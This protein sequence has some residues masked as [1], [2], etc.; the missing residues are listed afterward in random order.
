MRKLLFYGVVFFITYGSLYPFEFS[1]VVSDQA[2]R[3]FLN[4]AIVLSS[5][6][7][8]VGNVVLFVPFGFLGY[9]LLPSWVLVSI[10]LL[11]AVILQIAQLFLPSREP[12]IY[13][14][15][16]NFL[17]I[18]FGLL[19]GYVLKVSPLF[20]NNFCTTNNQVAIVII[21]LWGA[22]QLLP[23]VPTLDWQSF[24]SAL[25]PLTLP[26]FSWE[27]TS[28]LTFGW[29]A[30][31]YFSR[32]VLD[33]NW[34]TSYFILGVVSILLLKIMIVS[35][36]LNLTDV[37][38]GFFAVLIYLFLG[39]L[40]ARRIVYLAWLILFTYTLKSLFPFQWQSE[41]KSFIWLPLSGFLDGSMIINSKALCEKLFV[42]VCIFSLL[43]EAKILSVKTISV[44]II[45]IATIEI[46]QLWIAGRTAEITDPLLATIIAWLIVRLRNFTQT[47]SKLQLAETLQLDSRI[48]QSNTG[49]VNASI[50]RG[51][52]SREA[53]SPD[54]RVIVTA[55]VI[56]VVIASCLYVLLRMPNV[57]YNIRELFKYGGNGIDLFI[58]ALALLAMGGAPAW[59]GYTVAKAKNFIVTAPMTAIKVSAVIYILIFASVTDESI[60]DIAG[61]SVIV[62]R[63]GEKGV[64]GTVGKQFVAAVGADNL[65]NV[66]DIFEPLV[67][68]GALFGPL[69]IFLGLIFAAL[70]K[71]Q[72]L[73]NAGN[74][75]H[76]WLFSKQLFIY[77]LYMLPW[78]YFCKVIAFDWSSTDNLNE[79]IARDGYYRMGGGGYLYVLI[80][81][82]S[83]LAGVLAWA[84]QYSAFFTI[85]LL[86][87]SLFSV[88]PGWLLINAGLT[89]NVGKYGLS[90]SGV[91]FL[92]GPDRTHLLSSR[93]LFFRWSL[94]QYSAILGLASGAALYLK[95]LIRGGAKNTI[96]TKYA[97]SNSSILTELCGE[98]EINQI[99]FVNG[100][101][102][103]MGK[104]FSETVEFIVVFF[105]D[106]MLNSPD[107]NNI[108]SAKIKSELPTKSKKL[109]PVVLNLSPKQMK[110]ITKIQ[111]DTGYSC[112]EVIGNMISVFM[113]ISK[114]E[115][116][117]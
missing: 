80:A 59:M 6:G 117:N 30:V 72:S 79:L 46:C 95:L 24:K 58:F 82:I 14:V 42:F 88:W 57:P 101:A 100:F 7:D 75:L 76:S 104:S 41:G 56:S 3:A 84:I 106:E 66:T 48:L 85:L 5:I 53:F 49:F 28:F 99:E 52:N 19:C 51:Q 44:V 65:R 50:G 77:L 54:W 17:G 92:L 2:F 27:R 29:L 111:V 89:N 43:K 96:Q 71:T 13:D 12:A 10:G 9:R 102:Q 20:K 107:S 36:E 93:E 90:F 116:Q 109:L 38:A 61:S 87:I 4:S 73:P 55:L 81:L 18:S 37:F 11:L 91:D 64:L 110:I 68:F 94:V 62:H 63:V 69:I 33:K 70:F 60:M 35:N 108:F 31:G 39:K 8:V 34:H 32:K 26:S 86:I 114:A 74:G 22:L 103:K 67:R 105:K 45:I 16:W 25:K 78:F 98:L 21:M 15:F 115:V 83:L 23:F 112:F 40:D 1:L 47:N 113:V 97:S